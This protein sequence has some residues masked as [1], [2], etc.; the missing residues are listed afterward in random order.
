MSLSIS[1]VELT[2]PRLVALVTDLDNDQL[3]LYPSGSDY[4]MPLDEMANA[5]TYPFVAEW[6]GKPIGCACLYLS[7]EGIA[8]IKRVYV[9]PQGR[10]KNIASQLIHTLEE[11]VTLLKITALYLE[12]GVYREA[13]IGLYK[14]HGFNITG[15]FGD[16]VF[17]PLSVYMVKPYQT[18]QP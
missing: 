4:S 15:P 5:V 17:D 2:D 3:V 11:Q 6:E 16:Y 18:V 1:R 8:E 7:S 14:K 10:G 12:T 9:A 13:A